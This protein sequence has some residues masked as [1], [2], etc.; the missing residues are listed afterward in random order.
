MCFF[1]R[2][3]CEPLHAGPDFPFVA[4]NTL[5]TGYITYGMVG[6]RYSAYPMILYGIILILVSLCST[7]VLI[8]AAFIMPTQVCCPP[9]SPRAYV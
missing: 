1:L 2:R 9:M 5:V 4:V 6:L 7:Q 8:F 3:A